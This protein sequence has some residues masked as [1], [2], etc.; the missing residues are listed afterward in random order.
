VKELPPVNYLIQKSK[1]SRP[2]ITHVDKLKPWHTD[3]PP[4]LWLTDSDGDISLDAMLGAVD[5]GVDGQIPDGVE[6]DENPKSLMDG[7]TTTGPGKDNPDGVE[8]VRRPDDY[9]G[10]VVTG[11]VN[12][13]N[14]G[15][16][17]QDDSNAG[18]GATVPDDSDSTVG[19]G[20]SGGNAGVGAG[21]VNLDST[22]E[23]GRGSDDA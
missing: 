18:V 14:G 3:N 22:V 5:I 23:F 9:A 8:D 19:V 11:A 13:D 21:L 7:T 16:I 20:W 6:A 10:L 12:S 17:G 15:N 1:R 4:K 2:F